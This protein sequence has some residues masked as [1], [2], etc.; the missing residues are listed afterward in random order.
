MPFFR[1]KAV[2][3]QGEKVT[4]AREAESRE[5]LLFDLKTQGLYPVRIRED[6]QRK[7]RSLPE[8]SVMDFTETL[9]LLLSSGLSLKD[10]LTIML[11]IFNQGSVH[12][13]AAELLSRIEKGSSLYQ[14]LDSFEMSLPSVYRGLI[15]IGERIGSLESIVQRLS[16]Y[17][18]EAQKTM[19]LCW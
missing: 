3:S 18:R 16:T 15:K 7:T 10:A 8:S 13:V 1:G 6:R 2:N 11:T 19:S 4:Y 9:G 12:T 17:L 5:N 14:A